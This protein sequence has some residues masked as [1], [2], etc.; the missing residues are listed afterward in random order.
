MLQWCIEEAASRGATDESIVCR[1]LSTNFAALH[2]STLVRVPLITNL[3]LAAP[4]DCIS[5]EQSLTHALYD[6]AAHPE[7]HQ[8]MREEVEAVVA[9]QEPA[10]VLSQC[11]Q[12]KHAGLACDLRA[13][14]SE[15]LSLEISRS[16]RL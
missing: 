11:D 3:P 9:S 2:T 1:I 16:D 6:L 12:C 14:C 13:P 4:A 7:C 8:E 10:P 15:L 5:P